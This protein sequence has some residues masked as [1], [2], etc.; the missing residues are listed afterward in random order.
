[1][2][3]SLTRKVSGTFSNVNTGF[4]F[5]LCCSWIIELRLA[6]SY[7]DKKRG[8]F[9][10]RK[11]TKKY[12]ILTGV[13]FLLFILFTVLVT[14]IDVK[15][16][17]PEQSK[18][19]FAAL[20]QFVSELFGVNMLWYDI[21]DWLGGVAIAVAFGFAVLG[22]VQLIKRRSIRKVDCGLLL[23]GVFYFL[24]ILCYICF[25]FVVINYRPVILTQ[26]LEASYPSSHTMV[27]ICIM[28]T[29]MLQ[30]SHYFGSRKKWLLAADI[31]SVL[32]MIVTVAGR[33]ISGVHWFTDILGGMILAS[34]LIAFYCFTLEY[35]KEQ[36]YAKDREYAK[37]QQGK[38]GHTF[39][40]KF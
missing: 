9:I 15:P 28:V 12:L 37:E 31:A 3:R 32:L 24:V 27:V 21:T 1:M 18:V 23:L 2:I 40:K 20:N 6:S 13:L 10:M 35:A 39:R 29:A 22:L 14:K 11:K 8:K 36:E 33:I 34:A 25:E 26:G 4:L 17:G 7:Y 5:F 30:F 38:A 16:I 19:G